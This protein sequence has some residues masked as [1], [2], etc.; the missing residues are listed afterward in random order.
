MW[1]RHLHLTDYALWNS[2]H[3]KDDS[4]AM[5]NSARR[6]CL[7]VGENTVVRL[8]TPHG[9]QRERYTVIQLQ[10]RGQWRHELR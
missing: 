3:D 2:Y 5:Q 1:G 9:M 4:H 7:C 10:N 6:P 8:V